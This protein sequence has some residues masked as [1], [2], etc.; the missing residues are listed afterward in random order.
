MDEKRMIAELQA[1]IE[2]T[3]KEKA[4]LE[5]KVRHAKFFLIFGLVSSLL[6]MFLLFMF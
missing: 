4:M 5:N 6:L 2:K 1:D 3:V